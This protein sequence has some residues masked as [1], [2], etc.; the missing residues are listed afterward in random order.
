M[1]YLVMLLIVIGLA[2]ADYIT[3]CIKAYI[4]DDIKSVK[5]RKGGLN[6]LAEIV[7]M[8]VAIGSEVGFGQLGKYYDHQELGDIAGEITA[9]A[10]F[11]YIFAMEVVSILENYAEINPQAAWIKKLTK[12]L[13]NVSGNDKNGI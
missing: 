12:K 7:I 3:G 1:K 6:K 13:S 10:V 2:V 5:M 11:I 4:R 9:I 8:G